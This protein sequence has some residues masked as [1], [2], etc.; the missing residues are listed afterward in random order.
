MKYVYITIVIL[1]FAV[2]GCGKSPEMPAV[3][4]VDIN[5]PAEETAGEL[6]QEEAPI[7]TEE[8]T[9]ADMAELEELDVTVDSEEDEQI[10]AEVEEVDAAVSDA[11]SA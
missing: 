8:V 3:P 1:V 10:V 2:F 11:A 6:S 7:V 9:D 5:G 4:E